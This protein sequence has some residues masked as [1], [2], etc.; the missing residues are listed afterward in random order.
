MLW[1]EFTHLHTHTQYS[2]LDGACKIPDLIKKASQY[3]MPALA[4]TDHGNMFGVIEFYLEAQNAGIKPIIGCEV[5]IAPNSRFEKKLGGIE[6]TSFHF[7][8][9]AKDESGYRNLMKL[10]SAGYLEG[11]YYRPRIDKEILSQHA[12]GLIG[13]SSCLKAEIPLLIKNGQINT[14][15]K[16]CDEFNSIFGRNNFYLE[17]MDNGLEE[18]KIV[19]QGLLKIS[20]DLNIPL[21]ATNDI[22]Y[23]KKEEAKAHEALLC[24]QTQTTLQDSK[25]L[26]FQTEEFYFKSPEEMRELFKDLPSALR[27]T[28]EISERCNLELDFS[29]VHLPKYSPPGSSSC[30]EYLKQLCY[31]GLNKRYKEILPQIL[32]RLEHELKIIDQMGFQSYFLIVYDFVNYAK[33][34]GI[35]TGPGRGSVAGSLVSYLLGITD[36][37]P[38]K[39]SLIFERFLNPQRL[40]LPD[41]DID[42]CFERR[43][44]VIDYVIGKYGK[45]HVCQVITFGTMQARQAI[46]DVGRVMGLSY[47]QVDKIAKLISH[48][49]NI[50]L[51]DALRE[52]EFRLQY[53]TD[54]Q[55]KTLVDIALSLEGL[56]RHASVHAAGV[57]ISDRPLT[58]Y[59]PLFKSQEDQ[60][61]T[62]YDM[63]GLERIGL[64]KIDFLGLRTLTVIEQTIKLIRENQKISIDIDTLSL[65]DRETFKLLCEGNTLGVFQL[66]SSGMR[67][68]LKKLSPN[69]FEELIATLALYRPGPIGSGMVDDFIQRKHRK[70]PF[71]YLDKHLE[72]ILSSTYGIIV[73]QEQI[74]EIAS[75]LAGFSLAQADLLR[76]AMSKK[77]PEVMEEQR[78]EFVKGCIKNE[79]TQDRANKIFDLIEYF[80]GYGFNKSHSSAYA[81]ISYRTAYLK[82]NFPIEFM[83]SLLNSEKDNIEKIA[84]YVNEAN[85]LG[86]KVLPPDINKSFQNFTIEEGKIRF[87]LLAIK[88]VGAT[89]CE[90]IQREREKGGEFLSLEDF[91]RRV[92]LRT[93]N[94]K[95]IESLIKAGVFD[96]FGLF[97]SQMTACLDDVLEE[98][99]VIQKDRERGQLSLFDRAKGF[100]N[101]G[102]LPKIKEWPEPQLLSFEKEMLGFYISGHPLARYASNIKRFTTNST[103]QLPKLAD[104]NEV[105]IM[106]II[107]KIKQTTTRKNNEKMAIIKLED[108]EG[109]VEVI[110]FPTTYRQAYVYLQQ[111]TVVL[112]K[113]RLNLR[114]KT[115]KIIASTVISSQDVYNLISEIGIDLTGI[116][117]SLLYTLRERFSDFIG[118]IPV[119]LHSDISSQQ[120][121]KE[122][123]GQPPIILVQ[124]N[125]AF[126]GELESLLGRERLSLTL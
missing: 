1:S 99:S 81:L 74:I 52:T 55:V 57:V 4:I 36:I 70:I 35:S 84:E 5:Y 116:P 125:E 64:L 97:R 78:A 104:G 100:R 61:T 68:L 117:E 43:Q 121:I 44:E 95:V 72:S 85:R 10:V 40:G 119:R 111:N 109:D 62:G 90:S 77:I 48:D 2:L 110:I 26:R 75:K 66:E 120:R 93:V 82:A 69:C 31:E 3:K 98:A 113:G 126:I 92:D 32:E 11:F 105:K 60:I 124:P 112:V 118:N 65:D 24:I 107:I 21:V 18:Q 50:R 29:S 22:H 41:I 38:I 80:S 34:R 91:C 23:L 8:L 37:D 39:Y 47:S 102:A 58:D 88:N 27:N 9:L 20:K 17:L 86:I 45:D 19:N 15:F 87:G 89:A 56:S 83:A 49:P 54:P 94:R 63:G 51:E 67:E 42:F 46:R 33:S 30:K 6:E 53:S 123:F 73:Y 96:C 13:L 101:L 28:L 114:E 108:L 79:I 103:N 115:P 14:A 106:G 7:I 12:K 71:S 76:R 122:L 59:M 16:V 25:R